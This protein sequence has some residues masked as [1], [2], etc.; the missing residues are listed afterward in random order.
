MTAALNNS[1]TTAAWRCS[2]TGAT[3]SPQAKLPPAP[4]RPQGI[5][6][7]VVVTLW[8]VD[9][10]K[11]FIHDVIST[12]ERNPTANAYGPVYAPTLLSGRFGL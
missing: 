3:G 6:R 2:R 1:G 9:T 8:E 7:N 11:S 10:D 4:P 5:E 12:N